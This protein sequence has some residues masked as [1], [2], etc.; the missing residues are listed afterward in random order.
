M[1]KITITVEV[2]RRWE[3]DVELTDDQ[4]E[5]F[6]N[7]ELDE[8]QIE[9]IDFP[10]LYDKCRHNENADDESDYCIRDEEGSTIVDWN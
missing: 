4:Y 1:R 5:A 10:D 6:V 2:T 9:Q 3:E 7:G 8:L